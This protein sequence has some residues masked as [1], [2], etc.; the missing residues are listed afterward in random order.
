MIKFELVG[1]AG[2]TNHVNDVGKKSRPTSEDSKNNLRKNN[3]KKLSIATN[4]LFS[5]LDLIYPKNTTI[6]EKIPL[7]IPP[8][9]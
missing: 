9:R 3:K 2:L 1:K 4:Q 6:Q 5:V 7:Y 8:Q